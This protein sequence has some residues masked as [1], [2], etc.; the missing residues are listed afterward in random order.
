MRE[1]R[2]RLLRKLPKKAC[3][4]RNLKRNELLRLARIDFS[5]LQPRDQKKYFD[6]IKKSSDG[7]KEQAEQSAPAPESEAKPDGNEGQAPLSVPAPTAGRRVRV[8]GK[9]KGLAKAS[10]GTPPSPVATPKGK[11]PHLSSPIR[12][13]PAAPAPQAPPSGQQSEVV[14]SGSSGVTGGSIPKIPMAAVVKAGTIEGTIAGFLPVL[15]R[16]LGLAQGTAVM[17]VGFAFAEFAQKQ[18]LRGVRGRVGAAAVVSLAMKMEGRNLAPGD[19]TFVLKKLVFE[20][21]LAPLRVIEAEI[22]QA[23]ARDSGG[24]HGPFL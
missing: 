23:W 14:A 20:P 6:S 19:I 17:A 7:E 15:V 12:E 22:V 10:A 2:N 24:Q 16:S 18:R 13:P 3:K 21:E 11:D 1:H 5:R 4:D 8:R 9:T